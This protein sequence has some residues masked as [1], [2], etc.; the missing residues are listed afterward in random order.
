MTK[1]LSS[2]IISTSA[3]YSIEELE[4]EYKNGQKATYQDIL[5]GDTVSVFPITAEKEIYLIQQY[6]VM[7]QDYLIEAIAGF[8]DPGEDALTA[9][10]REAKEEAGIEAEN[11]K[12]LGAF[13]LAGSVVKAKDNLFYA[14]NVTLVAAA[15]EAGEEIEV[16][17]MPLPEAL[18]KIETGEIKTSATIIGLLKLQQLFQNGQL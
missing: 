13:Y 10:K 15:P 14:T 6:R 4:L 9:A 18:S 12:D 1:I 7:F 8:I 16:V 5:R 3:K 17:K 11:W 2:K